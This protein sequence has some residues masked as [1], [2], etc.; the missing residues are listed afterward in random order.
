V[1]HYKEVIR[2]EGVDLDLIC[3]LP[4]SRDMETAKLFW[5]RLDEDGDFEKISFRGRVED[6][7]YTY[8]LST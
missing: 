6:E 7:S 1:E 5:T 4:N 3:P 8:V 2:P